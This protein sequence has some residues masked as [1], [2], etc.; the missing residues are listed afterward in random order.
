MKKFTIAL[1][2]LL[3][4]IV[5]N[6]AT[7]DERLT[8]IKA[9]S[10]VVD[11]AIT[12]DA[13]AIPGFL[14]LS[15]AQIT[16]YIQSGNV[17]QG[18]AVSLLVVNSGQ[19]TEV[20]YWERRLPSVLAPP[21]SDETYI[22]D[23]ATPFKKPQ[24]ETFCN[25]L[26]LE[27][28]PGVGP[29]KQLTIANIDGTTVRVSGEFDIGNSVRERRDYYLWVVDVSGSYAPNAANTNIKFERIKASTP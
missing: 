26:W 3:V 15:I 12:Q 20:A 11:A 24:I 7:V 4:A 19:Q 25:A 21:D 6:A 27:A 5:S 16:Y 22:T 9:A 29:I 13:T 18:N 14:T 28:N 1:M 8:E 2:A 23:R 17:A 10:G